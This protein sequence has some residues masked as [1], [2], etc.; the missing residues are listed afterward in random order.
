MPTSSDAQ[1]TDDQIVTLLSH[2]L[3]GTV[4]NDE[5]RKGIEEIGTDELAPGQRTAVEELLV[6][7]RNALPG[8]RGELEKVIRETLESLAYGE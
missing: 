8:E 5:L 3:M 1:R 6:E 4:G 7:L 2:W